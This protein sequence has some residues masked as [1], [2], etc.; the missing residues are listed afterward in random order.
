[1]QCVVTAPV[2]QALAALKY[3][4][5][6]IAAID[7]SFAAVVIQRKTVRPAGGMPA[8][9]RRKGGAP[10]EQVPVQKPNEQC[11]CGSGKKYKKCCRLKHQTAMVAAS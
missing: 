6:E 5:E 11:A 3:T 10:A 4:P 7:P 8:E 1:M 9:F 2:R